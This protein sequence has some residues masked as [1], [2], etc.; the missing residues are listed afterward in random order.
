MGGVGQV[1]TDLG[2]PRSVGLR[3]DPCDL[4]PP[5]RQLDHKQHHNPHQ[6]RTCSR[7]VI[8]FRGLWR[9]RFHYRQDTVFNA[10][11]YLALLEQLGVPDLANLDNSG[12][13][14]EVFLCPSYPSILIQGTGRT[15]SL[16]LTKR[17]GHHETFQGKPSSC[18]S[19]QKPLALDRI[20]VLVCSDPLEAVEMNSELH[21]LDRS[22]T[23]STRPRGYSQF[24]KSTMPRRSK[25]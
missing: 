16:T 8:P 20:R 9:T 11:S 2:H 24:R 10:L 6:T 5:R 3:A 15:L 4:D 17:S 21:P 12:R 1:A 25:R 18:Y 23:P 22:V 19:Y 7:F 13:N 14:P